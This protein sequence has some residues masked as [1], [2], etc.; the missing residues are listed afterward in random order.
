MVLVERRTE[1]I[2][3]LFLY[4]IFDCKLHKSICDLMIYRSHLTVETHNFYGMSTRII[5]SNL[6]NRNFVSTAWNRDSF[7]QLRLKRVK[8]TITSLVITQRNSAVCEYQ[9][10]ILSNVIVRIKQ[11]YS[12]RFLIFPLQH[13]FNLVL[14]QRK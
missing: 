12:R 6:F 11:V 1:I 10:P 7:F 13:C 3:R 4:V 5:C 8:K 14:K 9:E 2:K